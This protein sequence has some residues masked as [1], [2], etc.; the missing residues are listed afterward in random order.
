LTEHPVSLTDD[1][2]T[3]LSLLVRVEPATAYQVSKIY[4]D[5]PVSNFG[6]RKGK[7]YP[8]IHRLKE[9]GLIRSAPVRGDGR[10]SEELSS[11]DR[12]REAVR[13]WVLEIR[14]R[15]LLLE[16]PLRTKVQSFGLLDRVEQLAWIGTAKGALRAKLA[17]VENYGAD[18]DVP[19]KD[20]VHD[21]AVSSLKMRLDWLD[22]LESSI[23]R[24]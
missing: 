23:S 12:G 2:A 18:V 14:E 10:G 3:F 19:Y 11:T 1:E 21:N 7:I 13:Q 9:R 16:D 4:A 6:T 5:S 24:G 17:E 15:H 20:Q 22:R 8:L